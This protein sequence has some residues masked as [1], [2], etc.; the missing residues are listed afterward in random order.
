LYSEFLDILH[1]WSVGVKMFGFLMWQ[2]GERFGGVH[3][4][5]V[6]R[7]PK[8]TKSDQIRHRFLQ[9]RQV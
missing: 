5:G 3:T 9:N 7:V 4:M 1:H 6:F 8:P 2:F